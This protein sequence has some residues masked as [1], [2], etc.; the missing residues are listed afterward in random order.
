MEVGNPGVVSQF[1]TLSILVVNNQCSRSLPAYNIAKMVFPSVSTVHNSRPN[2]MHIICSFIRLGW[3][4][5]VSG[6]CFGDT[7][8]GTIRKS[9]LV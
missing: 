8:L 2:L 3:N 7:D 9:T 4:G 5:S 1:T 6:V